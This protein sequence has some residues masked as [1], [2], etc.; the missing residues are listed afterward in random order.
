[1][2]A[3]RLE[4]ERLAPPGSLA[5]AVLVR[6]G[7]ALAL[8]PESCFDA[9]R[10]L[11]AVTPCKV[12]ADA[13]QVRGAGGQER[14]DRVLRGEGLVVTTGQQP[15]LFGGPLYV[16][17]KALTA[18]RIAQDVEQALG[19][20][21]LAVFWVA[22][23]DHDWPEVA[24]L[25]LLDPS[26]KLVRL[27]VE[28]PPDWDGR[29][30]GRAPIPATVAGLAESLEQ[31]VS[32][33]EEGRPWLRT[34][35]SAYAAGRSFSQAF[36]DVLGGWLG[37]LP[38]AFLDSCSQSIRDASR[39]VFARVMRESG[40]IEE[41]LRTGARAVEQAGFEPQLTHMPGAA[42][43][44]SEGAGGRH[45][46]YVDAGMV[47]SGR[48]G[49]E[50]PLEAVLSAMDSDSSRFSPSA[51][52][53]PVLESLLLPVSTTVL[54]PGEIAYWT[55]LGPLFHALG[56]TMP[57]IRP[58]SSWRFIEP[59]VDRL[60]DKTGL[61]PADLSDG[62]AEATRNLV[63]R[64][65]PASVEEALQALDESLMRGFGDLQDAA[66]REVPGL[67]PSIGKARSQMGTAL[68]GFRKAL[69]SNT[70]DRERTVLE[71]ARRAARNLF[72]GGATQERVIGTVQYVG[73]YGEEFLEMA[74]AVHSL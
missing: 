19:H 43:L 65:R 68:D 24:S 72:P 6:A 63:T 36:T 46:L 74:R 42:P 12:P 57:S 26:E 28:T 32:A 41:A 54:G 44:F 7:K 35:T 71:Q 18:I 20:P 48:R 34:L 4:P 64:S 17:Y 40:L 73:R 51:A 8:F 58:R 53:R 13:F 25:G 62:G 39:P 16:L 11:G 23:D 27:T 9:P 47:R 60:L 33:R 21:C 61:V 69:D 70:R 59:K 29:S 49:I 38:I 10:T 50:A 22:S 45:R 56:A 5:E 67:R 52:L 3:P 66:D 2:S 31:L 37:D 55:Q 14:L 15:Q 1:M 30:V